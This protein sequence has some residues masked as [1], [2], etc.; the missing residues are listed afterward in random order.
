M[1]FFFKYFFKT[2]RLVVGPMLLLG[3]KLNPPRGVVRSPEK[4]KQIDQQC[5]ALALYQ[6]RTCP[7]CLK[8]RRAL[9]RQSL[10]IE[11]RDAQH[12]AQ[13]RADLL[14]GGGQIKVPCLRITHAQSHT[15]WLYES[16][17]IIE[18]LRQRFA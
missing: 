3:E 16:S 7:F 8:T 6:F 2:V 4:Q 15:Q 11:L 17:E 5:Q 1:K 18:Y 12:N 9:R 14:Q 13:H 10:K